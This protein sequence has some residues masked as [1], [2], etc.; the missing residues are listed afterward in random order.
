MAKIINILYKLEILILI[1][2]LSIISGVV[3]IEIVLRFYGAPLYWSEELARYFFIWLIMIGCA[4]GV[5][6]KSH[7]RVDFIVNRFKPGLQRILY[8]FG[9]LMGVIF[10]SFLIVYGVILCMKTGTVLSPALCIPQYCG[11]MAIPVGSFLMLV[12][13]LSHIYDA[14]TYKGK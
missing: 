5:H 6:Q 10:L 11:Y 13:F 1:M 9:A 12:H 7:F 3:I 2:S 14:L 8:V 4:A